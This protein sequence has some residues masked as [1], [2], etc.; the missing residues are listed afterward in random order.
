[1]TTFKYL[2]TL[3][4][5]II[6]SGPFLLSAQQQIYPGA[7]EH[8]PSRSEY[9]SWINNTNEG[10]TEKQTL[11]NLDFFKWLKD[12]YGMHLDIYAMDAGNIDGKGFCGTIQSSRFER[13]FPN[14][15][16]RIYKE[17]SLMNTR[18]G[19]W[20]GPDC[21]G[22]TVASEKAR[23]DMMVKLCRDYKFELFK[24][25]KVNGDL[26][27]EKQDAFIK[28]MKECRIYSPDLILLNHRLNLGKAMPYA[29]TF[30][31]GGDET[32]I[33]VNMTNTQTAPHHRQ[34]ALSREGV[35][36]LKRLTE[37]HGVCLSSCLDYW[38]DDLI[39]Q[40]FNRSLIL[41][42]EIYGNPW[43]LSD[44]EF[45]RLARI[46]NLHAK[47]DKILVNGIKLPKN[48]YGKNAVSRGDSSTRFITLR[49]MNWQSAT[50]T[51]SLNEEIGLL[52][53]VHFQVRQFHPTNEIIGNYNRGQKVK[54]EVLPFR[55]CLIGISASWDDP[56]IAGCQYEVVNEKN[57]H[58]IVIKLL[59]MPGQQAQI[60]LSGKEKYSSADI[61]GTP[62]PA[63]VK[64]KTVLINFPGTSLKEKW[65]RK[66]GDLLPVSMPEDA[67]SLYEATCFAADN[68]AL[69]VRSLYRSGPT[70][71]PQVQAA[72]DAFFEQP[73]FKERGLWDKY[74]FDGEAESGFEISRRWG[75]PRE[76]VFRL[77]LGKAIFL[78]KLVLKTTGEY[79]IQPLKTDEAISVEVSSD[80]KTWKR[81]KFLAG[82]TMHIPLDPNIPVRY[83][84]FN[85]NFSRLTEIEGYKEGKLID[86]T[87]WRASN[88]FAEWHNVKAKEAWA[89]SF[90]LKEIPK[91][92]Y[93]CIALNGKHGV[94]GAYAAIR[95]DGKPV[96]APDRS[97]SY[98]SNTWEYK[99]QERDS[100]YTYYIPLA[101]EME[102]K[103]IDAIVLGLKN[104][105]T[106]F[107]PEVWITAYPVPFEKKILI[108]RRN[109]KSNNF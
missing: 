97:V 35:P 100:D 32:Y 7:D 4:F 6:V 95:I 69:E 28:M 99:V 62:V 91:G 94:E 38:E 23:I 108:L 73:L 9:F 109:N 93:L 19:I 12:K 21:F 85:E 39:L 78:N 82:K 64:G 14:S 52:K 106:D 83:F 101:K 24:F 81:I 68:N 80:L 48:N 34:G 59:G 72:R 33:D 41:A 2:R 75:N 87:G 18:L 74:L 98:S 30:L 36:G 102:G 88:L 79:D 11:I 47:Y 77:D 15:F 54:V 70:L 3:A 51:I 40:A 29:T 57:G 65:H 26:R 107:K 90:T 66:L 31:L 17:A 13:Q 56:Q 20:G 63:L 76:G 86:R 71:I 44:N 10:S 92:S 27:T 96:G 60:R 53:G 103:K 42:P 25:D 58:P 45:P 1:M 49:N 5:S 61:D 16:D 8:S 89:T 22:N 50:F 84:R 105:I 67:E 104:G 37:D 55:S 46:F 43:L